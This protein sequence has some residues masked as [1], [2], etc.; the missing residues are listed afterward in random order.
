MHVIAAKAVA[1]KEAAE[2]AFV[3]YQEQVLKNA[4][5]FARS[6]QDY[7]FKLVS[8]GT[9]N[10][11]L[12]VDL[13]NKQI[14]GRDAA[15]LLDDVGITVNKNTIPYDTEN[16]VVTSGIRIGTPA[17]TTRGMKEEEM[18]AIA[19]F[20][21]RVIEG[22]QDPDVLTETKNKVKDLCAGFPLYM[23]LL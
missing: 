3:D 11:L 13:R 6:L 14:T 12:L 8:D 1:F 21:Y 23:D 4:R 9:D 16:P 18:Q 22:R 5:V 10:H 7:G 15:H 17:V 2:K 20:I 19:G